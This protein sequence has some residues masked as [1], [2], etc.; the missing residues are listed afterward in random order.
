MMKNKEEN[1]LTLLLPNNITLYFPLGILEDIENIYFQ[2]ICPLSAYR[3][4]TECLFQLDKCL[5]NELIL[6]PIE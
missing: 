4:E 6:Q 1:D 2:P 5:Y 3:T